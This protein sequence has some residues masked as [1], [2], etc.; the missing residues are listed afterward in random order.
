MHSFWPRSGVV[1]RGAKKPIEGCRESIPPL[2][3]PKHLKKY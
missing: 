2:S 3:R 1:N